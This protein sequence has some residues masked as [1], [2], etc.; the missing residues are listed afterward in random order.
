M[1]SAEKIHLA[2]EPAGRRVKEGIKRAWRRNPRA[3]REC[4]VGHRG[5]LAN[6]CRDHS[7]PSVLHPRFIDGD[8]DVPKF[9]HNQG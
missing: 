5:T 6:S 7:Q 4:G 9:T 1:R 2:G 8:G 3:V